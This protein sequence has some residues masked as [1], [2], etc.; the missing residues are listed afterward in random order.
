LNSVRNPYGE[1][2][3]S[4][5]VVEILKNYSIDDVVKKVFYD[6]PNAEIAAQ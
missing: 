1:G 2:G 3:A 5:R 6:L 4:E